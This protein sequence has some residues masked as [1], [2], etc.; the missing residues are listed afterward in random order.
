MG[1]IINMYSPDEGDES[2]PNSDSDDNRP[3]TKKEKSIDR[4]VEKCYS[5]LNKMTHEDVQRATGGV[6]YKSIG[7]NQDF[8]FN[9]N[10]VSDAMIAIGIFLDRT[11]LIR[12]DLPIMFKKSFDLAENANFDN[13]TSFY[14]FKKILDPWIDPQTKGRKKVDKKVL[15]PKTKR[16]I[17]IGGKSYKDVFRNIKLK[18]VIYADLENYKIISYD[19][20][21]YCVVS[22][23]KNY[24]LKKEFKIIENDLKENP[25]PTSDELEV[26]LNK[27]NYNLDIFILDGECISE[28]N[29]YKKRLRIMIH[30]EHMYVL[31]NCAIEKSN[32]KITECEQNEFDK[33]KSEIY[34]ES[35]KIK[36]GIKYKIKDRFGD[37]EK[38]FKMRGPF[39]KVNIDF[40]DQCGIRAPRYI[41]IN[42][43]N[44]QTLDIKKC[45]FNILNNPRYIFPVQDGN[46][47]TEVY[48]KGERIEPHGFYF[49]EFK[50][51]LSSI[52]K[53]LFTQKCWILG[54]LITNLKMIDKII[55]KFKHIANDYANINRESKK[56][57]KYLDVI[58]YTGFLSRYL[59]TTSNNYIC[60]GLEMDAFKLKYNNNTVSSSLRGHLS[61]ETIEKSLYENTNDKIKIKNMNYDTIEERKELE[62][63]LKVIDYEDPCICN[64]Y[65]YFLQ[66]SGMYSYIAIT[67]YA[68]YELYLINNEISKECNINIHK[69][70]TDSITYDNKLTDEKIQDLNSILLKKYGFGISKKYSN[71]VWN[72]REFIINEPK[73]TM[74]SKINIYDNIEEIMNKNQSFCINARAG[75]GKS[76]MIENVI[77]PMINDQNKKYILTSTTLKSSEKINC[78]CINTILSS[79]ESYLQKL[80]MI[81]KDIDYLIVDECSRL[82]DHLLKMIEYVQLINKKI[83]VIMVGD[84]NQCDGFSSNC[85]IMDSNIFKRICN[86]NYFI[87]K[88]HNNARYCKK[89]DDFLSQILS[90]EQGGKNKDCVKLI[91][92]F[93]KDQIKGINDN[94]NNKIKLTYTHKT[95]EILLGGDYNTTH[96]VQGD[97]IDEQYSIYEINKM[98]RKVLYTALS[99]ASNHKL[100][101]IFI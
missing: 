28:Q 10:S 8:S 32:C 74:I 3:K 84:S 73:V 6:T 37:I 95:G 45:Y 52:E 93:F 35:S 2:A 70:Y 46:E 47:K 21:E 19:V 51:D 27:I 92:T 29:E 26:I 71:H 82:N 22:Y 15:N 36:D 91:K 43:E 88:W 53:S 98:P 16:F 67:Q 66:S 80:Q 62:K 63:T 57:H 33:I 1:V 96:S 20:D 13:H 78:K 55:I 81:F 100:I 97:T 31:K 14:S 44:V 49:I 90:F 86:N 39:T 24:L 94:D 72:Q 5:L 59:R 79:N 23:L 69:I 89:Y 11:Y 61:F 75:Y 42:V 41:D 65:E 30:D 58:H 101:N 85:D 60:N 76:Y 17:K 99:R 54:Y 12:N 7:K 48:K 40:Y 9:L 64:S 34:T 4:F 68:R 18:K 50:D 38:D 83:K 87:M 77:I 56:E 25:T